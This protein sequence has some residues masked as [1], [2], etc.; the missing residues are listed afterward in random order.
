[1]RFFIITYLF[2]R[3]ELASPALPTRPG[4]ALFVRRAK[5]GTRRLY[6]IEKFPSLTFSWH[7]QAKERGE[8]LG[9]GSLLNHGPSFETSL[10]LFAEGE[11]AKLG[12]DEKDFP[13]PRDF[14]NHS[15]H[16]F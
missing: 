12:F 8:I 3:W 2:A 14:W 5:G 6:K 10:R 15:P 7:R 13:P 11:C 16:C 4:P 1:M 9:K